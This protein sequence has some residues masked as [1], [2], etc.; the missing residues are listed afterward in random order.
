MILSA[1]VFI[2]IAAMVLVALLPKDNVK[3]FRTVALSATG[4]QLIL[5]LY[6]WSQFNSAMGGVNDAA[7]F[8]FKEQHS[9]IR[10]DAGPIL[11]RVAIDYFLGIDGLS[12]P[13]VLLTAIVCF[14]ATFSSFSIKHSLKGYFA[15]FLLLDAAMMGVFMAL[16]FFLFYLFWE[17]MLLP[18]YFL[19]GIWG[20]PRREYAAIKFFLYTLFGSIFML[21]VMI[22]LY[23]SVQSAID[24]HGLT[25]ALRDMVNPGN[26]AHTF[27]LLAMMNPANYDANSI[28]GGMATYW[29]VVAFIGLF[30]GF[31][32]KVPMVPFHTWLPDAHVEAPTPISVILA[33]VLL[34]M[35]TYGMLRICFSVFPDVTML[36]AI[37][38][39]I[40]IFGFINI[41]YGALVA[42]AQTDMKKLIAYSSVSH[43]G[44][45]LLGMAAINTQGFAGTIFQMFNHGIITS[46]LFLLIGVLYDRTHVRG[47]NDFGGLW[48]RMPRYTGFVVVAFFAAMGLPA[49]SGFI[50]EA[51]VFIGAFQGVVDIRFWTVLSTLG[52]IL[53]A[54]YMLWLFQRGWMGTFNEKWD[55]VMTD[56]SFREAF[57]LALL[58]VIVIVLGSYPA[59]MIDM[60]KTTVNALVVFITTHGSTVSAVVQ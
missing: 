16:D 11:G 18:M 48:N 57:P 34:K 35:G 22:A 10:L 43:M 24:V 49:L 6:L 3:L 23:F 8:Q 40:A 9:W 37:I 20:G 44:Y 59:P 56:L 53:G 27:N 60:M 19:I 42:M 25:T 5:A 32:I 38:E 1:L 58:A 55:A 54:A 17:V 41:V 14:V 31:A 21:L 30:V 15:M 4:L 12:M 47:V 33:G 26:N 36:P 52:I 46:M 28:L 39:W 29:R 45:C 2:P 51:F 7:S 13:M 50:S